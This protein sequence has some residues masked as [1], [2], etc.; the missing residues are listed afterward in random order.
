MPLSKN[1]KCKFFVKYKN[2]EYVIYEN[3][4]KFDFLENFA[5]LLYND[6]HELRFEKMHI[7]FVWLRII[8]IICTMIGLM[9]VLENLV[10]HMHLEFLKII[11][12]MK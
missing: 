1:Y 6:L 10:L 9:V 12:L 5:Q 8:F 3:S 2:K 7:W 4:L 11:K